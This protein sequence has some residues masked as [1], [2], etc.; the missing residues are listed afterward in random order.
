MSGYGISGKVFA[1]IK[2]FMCNRPLKVVVNGQSS[3]SIGINAGVPQGSLL[4]PTLF[5]I[6]IND[7]PKNT[8]K[9]LV[10]IYADDTTVYGS[11]S[12]T[13]DDQSLAEHLSADLENVVEWGKTWLVSFNS[14]KTKL[15]SFH[16]H[17]S[18]PSV[19][20]VDM[21]STAFNEAPCLEKLL[22]LKLTPDL[23]WNDY[24]TSIAKEAAKMVGNLYRLMKVL[25]PSIAYLYKSQIAP[26]M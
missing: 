11:T 10:N 19:H 2:S 14:R 5:L 24:I 21:D 25:T 1:I 3:E 26:Q 23:K 8:L 13:A 18:D 22:G 20:P 12:E 4:G 9:S 7:L 16:H 17:H 15:I 6:F